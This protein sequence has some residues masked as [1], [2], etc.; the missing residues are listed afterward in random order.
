MPCF[1]QLQS[2]KCHYSHV[3]SFKGTTA[4]RKWKHVG[5]L[6]VLKITLNGNE[7]MD[8]ERGTGIVRRNR[9]H[10]LFL[11]CVVLIAWFWHFLM[12]YFCLIELC[13]QSKTQ[14]GGVGITSI[15]SLLIKYKKGG[16]TSSVGSFTSSYYCVLTVCCKWLLFFL[17]LTHIF[18]YFFNMV[19]IKK[20]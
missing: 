20:I 4:V 8:R 9:K 19:K 2:L 18:Y 7:M 11:I 17:F 16:I 5:H 15:S 14:G 3:C 1:S 12:F 10:R 13:N 6:S